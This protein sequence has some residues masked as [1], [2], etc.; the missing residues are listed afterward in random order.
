MKGTV[1]DK[2][3]VHYFDHM[4]EVFMSSHNLFCHWNAIVGPILYL[5]GFYHGRN[6]HGYFYSNAQCTEALFNIHFSVMKRWVK[7]FV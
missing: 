6:V 5:T 2:L 3:F 1:K 7:R 4:N